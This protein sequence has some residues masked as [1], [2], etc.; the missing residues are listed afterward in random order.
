MANVTHTT[1]I[2]ILCKTKQ[3]LS[4][5]TRNRLIRPYRWTWDLFDIFGYGKWPHLDLVLPK[6]TTR[7]HRE[8]RTCALSDIN[9]VWLIN[10]IYLRVN[11]KW[12]PWIDPKWW[13]ICEPQS[14]IP[15]IFYAKM[16]VKHSKIICYNIP[17]VS[18]V[19]T[20]NGVTLSVFTISFFFDAIPL[21]Y[22]SIYIY[23][24]D[25]KALES[26][27]TWCTGVIFSQLIKNIST[28]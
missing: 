28:G 3:I 18:Q 4:F 20:K 22:G 25:C 12:W 21:I 14:T 10:S 6:W 9:F 24:S 5:M 19:L 16:W 27:G 7:Y 1:V 11:P 23:L 17:C 8:I 26:R 15:P 13:Q 2:T